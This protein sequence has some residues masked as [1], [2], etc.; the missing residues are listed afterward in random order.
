M[1]GN[2]VCPPPREEGAGGETRR[3]AS[4]FLEGAKEISDFKVDGEKREGS[5]RS[6]AGRCPKFLGRVLSLTG[7][8][9]NSRAGADP[10]FSPS[11]STASALALSIP[12]QGQRL[13]SASTAPF[14]PAPDVSDP[15][16]NLV[17]QDIWISWDLPQR[18]STIEL[19]LKP[20]RKC[21]KG[22]VVQS[23]GRTAD[24]DDGTGYLK[25]GM[26][27]ETSQLVLS[28][29]PKS[30]DRQR[31]VQTQ[32]WE[33]GESQP[34]SG[35]GAG[36][37]GALGVALG[38]ARCGGVAGEGWG[39]GQAGSVAPGGTRGGARRCARRGGW[40]R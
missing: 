37:S 28:P 36:G 25:S 16:T 15:G 7:R 21:M 18:R 20:F 8:G 38:V 32:Q 10:L 2:A 29:G 19:N 39:A 12:S 30:P 33:I 22:A 3:S 9:A 31:S 5:E 35:D 40:A 1:E 4:F 11:H 24:S 6:G 17:D 23:A 14:P 27:W 26:S 13:R 34:A